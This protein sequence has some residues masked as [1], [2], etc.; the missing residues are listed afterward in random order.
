MGDD[1]NNLERKNSFQ[2]FKKAGE[3]LN[4][5]FQ[6]LTADSQSYEAAGLSSLENLIKI[7]KASMKRIE[8]MEKGMLIII[9]AKALS[10]T[11]DII[12]AFGFNKPK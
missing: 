2:P 7:K 6:I 8:V 10:V 1:E 5:K 4:G 11:Y 12:K 3:L 9:G